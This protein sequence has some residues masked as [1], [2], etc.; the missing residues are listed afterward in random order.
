MMEHDSRPVLLVVMVSDL[1]KDRQAALPNFKVFYRAHQVV[2]S[3]H[4]EQV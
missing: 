2:A 3:P 4:L 1:E